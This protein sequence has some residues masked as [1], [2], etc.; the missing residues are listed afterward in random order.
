MA[1]PVKLSPE[2]TEALTGIKVDGPEDLF[3]SQ[4]RSHLLPPFVRQYRFAKHIGRQWRFDFAFPDFMLAVEIDGVVVRRIGVQTV[5]GGRHAT[6]T[7]IRGDNVKINTAQ[8]F[9]GWRVLRFLQSDVKP[10]HAV[11]FVSKAL[12][13]LGWKGPT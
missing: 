6:I 10:G 2:L 11:E 13:C 8:G 9:L 3:A 1:R 12:M 5:V 4:C 7:G